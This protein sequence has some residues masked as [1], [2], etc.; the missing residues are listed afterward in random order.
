MLKS[1]KLTAG[2][3]IVIFLALLVYAAGDLSITH[4]TA[5]TFTVNPGDVISGNFSMTNS[6]ATDALIIDFPN[7]VDMIGSSYNYTAN[8]NYNES[9]PY[10]LANNSAED[11]SYD[12]T[13]PSDTYAG[14]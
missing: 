5:T 13:I 8:V 1:L 2:F 4:T 10:I 3:L 12:M 7:P 11:I 9:E 14:S 6:N